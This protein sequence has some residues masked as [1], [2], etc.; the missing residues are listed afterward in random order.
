MSNHPKSTVND[1]LAELRT[2]LDAH[3]EIG[4]P[5]IARLKWPNVP[6]SSW[7]RYVQQAR[8]EWNEAL[9]LREAGLPASAVPP[10]VT[11]APAAS[12]ELGSTPSG[13]I[14]W[15]SQVT[16]LLRQ[17]DMLARQSI[18]VDVTTGI[19]RV[20]NPVVLQQSVRARTAVLKLAADREAVMFS[21]ERVAHWEGVLM[22][23]IGRAIGRVR[24]EDQRV[25][26]MR[27][28]RAVGGVLKRRDEER[29]HLGG[30]VSPRPEAETEESHDGK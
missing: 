14:A 30:S 16:A 9:R 2:Q 1:I 5:K 6:S 25:I 7:S 11:A 15:N 8:A 29:A 17:C 12:G 24:S 22:R 3:G 4:G 26:A 19:E 13:V 18:H 21:G 27:V 28:R 20:R 10:T 23:E